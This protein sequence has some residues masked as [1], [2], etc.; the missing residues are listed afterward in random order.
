L[1]SSLFTEPKPEP[2]PQPSPSLPLAR[3]FARSLRYEDIE[4]VRDATFA[5]ANIA[6]SMDLQADIVRQGGIEILSAVG[7]HD[8]ARVQRDVARAFSCLSVSE[9]VKSTIVIKGGLETLFK[10]ARSLDISSQRYAARA[11][12]CRCIFRNGG[13]VGGAVFSC[14]LY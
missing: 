4:V 11:K 12:R 9:D 2:E 5:C 6:D 14:H 3:S 7:K 10:L 1:L 8:D 13:A